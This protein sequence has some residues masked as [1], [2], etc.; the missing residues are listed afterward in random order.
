MLPSIKVML[1]LLFLLWCGGAYWA[2]QSPVMLIYPAMWAAVG[3]LF[4]VVTKAAPGE[5]PS[6]G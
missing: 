4:V 1:P 2:F 5:A 3:V 6:E